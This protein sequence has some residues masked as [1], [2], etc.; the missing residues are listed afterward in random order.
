MAAAGLWT[1]PTDL[2]R[3]LIEVQRSLKG[4][5]NHVLSQEMTKEMLTPG[6]GKWGLGLQIGGADAD[7]YFGHGGVNAGFESHDG[8]VRE[9]R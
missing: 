6:M 5:A 9:G 1:T 2:C 4:E 3:Y 7:P 8:G